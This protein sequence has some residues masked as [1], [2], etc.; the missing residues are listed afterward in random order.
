[1][2][3]SA[4]K[5]SFVL[6]IYLGIHSTQR[7]RDARAQSFYEKLN[8]NGEISFKALRLRAFAPLR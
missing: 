4:S 2:R 5:K 6:R 8:I 1:V 3:A 7:R